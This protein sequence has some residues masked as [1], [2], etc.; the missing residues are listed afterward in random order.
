[1]SYALYDETQAALKA[2]N[3][4]FRGPIG[5]RQRCDSI[6]GSVLVAALVDEYLG[7]F[8]KSV[9]DLVIAEGHSSSAGHGITTYG[10]SGS[11]QIVLSDLYHGY[12]F[13]QAIQAHKGRRER[14]VGDLANS[15]FE[16]NPAQIIRRY[17]LD[18]SGNDQFNNPFGDTFYTVDSIKAAINLAVERRIAELVAEDDKEHLGGLD[19]NKYLLQT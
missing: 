16:T 10:G 8:V 3:L 11:V 6:P 17:G 14:A 9:G 5:L 12:V 18:A 19:P 4:P 15:S 13:R 2:M 7:P 1:M